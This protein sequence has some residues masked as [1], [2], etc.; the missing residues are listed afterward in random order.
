MTTYDLTGQRFGCWVVLHRDGRIGKNAAWLC[1][2]DDGEIKRR[3]A[4]KLK[5]GDTPYVSGPL[6]AFARHEKMPLRAL[7]PA[8]Y[9]AWHCRDCGVDTTPCT[10]K[11]GCRHKKGRWELY[12][13]HDE[14]WAAAGMQHGYLCI[15]C[16]E[17]RIG[18]RL[19]PQDF[20]SGEHVHA[21]HTPRLASRLT[22][23]ADGAHD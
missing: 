13:V 14:L 12:L 2:S 19:V 6:S 4:D 22:G 21:W 10:G 5:K 16:L 7:L 1:M 3:R 17:A 23:A 15:G 9:R 8:A 20:V 18:R 11:R